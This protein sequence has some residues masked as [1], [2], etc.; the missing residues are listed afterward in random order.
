MTTFAATSDFYRIVVDN[1]PLIDVRAPVEF[2]GG[3]FPMAVNLPVMDD[4]DRHLVGIC[5]KQQGRDAAFNLAF[6]RVSGRKKEERIAAWTDFVEKHPNAL[7]YCFRG[8]MRSKTT[9]EWFKQETGKTIKRLDG[10]YKAFR[11]YLM[12]QMDPANIPGIP[13]IL[14]GRTGTGKT[15]LLRQLDNAIDLE[16]IANHRGSAFGRFLTPQPSQ[17]DFENRLACALINHRHN[18]YKYMVLEDEGAYIGTRYIPKEL[19]LYFKQDSVVLLESG[20]DERIGITYDE[21]VSGA[22]QD[23]FEL[24]GEESG[25]DHWLEDIQGSLGRIKKRLG[26]ER[27]KRVAKLLAAGHEEQQENGNPELHKKWVELLLSEYYDPMYDYQIEKGNRTVLFRGDSN[28][29]LQ[30]LRTL[31]KERC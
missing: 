7:C 3:A 11:R 29:V 28:E 17:I 19:A 27:L 15:I 4:E 23:Y 1:I 30:Y 22:Q 25:L 18:D 9:Q 31:E 8:G 20:L 10:G 13:I 12:E 24:Y 2:S 16:A 26:G 14:G 6:K 21:Y 5:Y